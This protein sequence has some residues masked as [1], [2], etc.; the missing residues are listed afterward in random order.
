MNLLFVSSNFP[1]AAHRSRGTYNGELCCALTEQHRVQV[2]APRTWSE[3]LRSIRQRRP[4]AAPPT[5]AAAGIECRYPT[6]LN[7]P[8][9]LRRLHGH[10]M[11]FSIRDDVIRLNRRGPIDGVLSYW[12][13]PDGETALRAARLLDVPHMVIVG[14]SD[15]LLLPQPPGR[16]NTVVNVLRS[17]QAV[18]TVSNGLR[19]AVI[20]FGVPEERVHTIYQGVDARIFR[21]NRQQDA[22]SRLGLS[23]ARARLLWVGRM[24]DVKALHIL[25]EGCVELQLRGTEF[26]LVIVGDGPLRAETATM[27]ENKGLQSRVRF[28]GAVGHDQLADWYSAADLTVLSSWSEGLPN[29]LRESLACGTPFVATNVGSIREIADPDCCALVD[30]GDPIGFA[31][32]VV[33]VLDGDHHLVAAHLRPRTWADCANEITRLLSKLRNARDC[34]SRLELPADDPES[35]SNSEFSPPQQPASVV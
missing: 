1:D 12:A 26:E 29:V 3:T 27:I 2:I 15:V 6:F 17:S 33:Q 32:A 34:E 25:V 28:V 5:F 23:G 16:R 24:V 21:P 22:R 4:F 7:T 14:G 31:D 13:H 8:G 35:T 9:V 20:N 11:W 18:V 30:P 10:S 19:Q